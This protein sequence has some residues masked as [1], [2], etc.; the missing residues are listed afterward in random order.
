MQC[1][2]WKHYWKLVSYLPISKKWV[3]TQCIIVAQFL[4]TLQ[5]EAAVVFGAYTP[6]SS[7]CC[8]LLSTGAWCLWELSI[9]SGCDRTLG[10]VTRANH[11]VGWWAA[12]ASQPSYRWHHSLKAKVCNWRAVCRNKQ[13][14]KKSKLLDKSHSGP[15]LKN[16]VSYV[17]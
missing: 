3:I 9:G 17:S 6:P 15:K 16:H 8:T 1:S 4:Q 11:E 2:T 10:F 12:S 7:L 14:S 5:H 13:K